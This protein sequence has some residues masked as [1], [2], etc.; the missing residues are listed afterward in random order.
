MNRNRLLVHQ[1]ES[2]KQE[3]EALENQI[4]RLE[5]INMDYI[6]NSIE[7]DW[8]LMYGIE[9]YSDGDDYVFGLDSECDDLQQQDEDEWSPSDSEESDSANQ[10]WDSIKP[11][12]QKYIS[13][14]PVDSIAN[15]ANQIIHLEI[16][17]RITDPYMMSISGEE[18]QLKKANMVT[19]G[20]IKYYESQIKNSI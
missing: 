15:L 11:R 6:T 17:K 18:I 8:N 5:D 14:Q 1:I 10:L 20:P 2:T 9:E 13:R 19:A 12:E 7:V 16:Q 3:S 4:R